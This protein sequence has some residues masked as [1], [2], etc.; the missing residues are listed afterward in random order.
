MATLRVLL[1]APPSADRA[2]AWV[3]VDERGTVLRRGRDVP[4][5]WPAAQRRE[6]VLAANAVR[7]LALELPPLPA[8]RVEQAVTYALEERL[9]TPLDTAVVVA[10][11]QG[12]D[13]RIV[14]L[15]VARTLARAIATHLPPFDRVVAE[16]Q[17]AREPPAGAWRWCA[18]EG[19]GFVLAG[20]GEAFAVGASERGEL[21]VDLKLALEQAARTGR[22]PER[23]VADAAAD[24]AQRAQ[25]TRATGVPMVGG[26]PWRWEAG[27]GVPASDL[28]PALAREPRP[29]ASTPSRRP[30]LAVA[31]TLVIAAGALHV[32][33]TAGTWA[34]R[35]LELGRTQAAMADV[36]RTAGASDAEDLARRHAAARHRAGSSVP[37]DAW[38]RLAQAAPALAALP[39]GTLRT[40]RY[41]GGAWTLELGTIDDAALAAFDAR[42]RGSGLSGV[43]ARSPSGVRVRIEEGES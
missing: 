25:W 36:A 9:A 7:L 39:P 12:A 19:G 42:L 27:D 11:P 1:P 34:W 13:G 38:P 33:A 20:K 8:A 29:A 2:D 35:K 4:S 3:L 37:Q 31:L 40:A 43:A 18:S 41:G 16:P 26:K 21:P 5:K 6:A 30:T 28:A 14:A 15:V 32:A 24:D 22:A 17:L 10:G 23:I